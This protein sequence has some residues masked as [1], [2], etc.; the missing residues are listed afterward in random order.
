MLG[1]GLIDL[2]NSFPLGLDTIISENGNNL[3]GGQ[4]QKISLIRTLISKP[5]IIFLD[6]PTSSMDVLSEKQMMELIFKINCTVV[7]VS[8]RISLVDKFDKILI[9]KN[10]KIEGFD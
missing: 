7:V 2:V 4:R 1:S 6:E 10:G 8:H 3:S 5:S 9:V